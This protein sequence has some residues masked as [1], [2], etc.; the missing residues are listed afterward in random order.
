[1]INF[2]AT[3][4]LM[5]KISKMLNISVELGDARRDSERLYMQ[6]E[7]AIAQKPDLQ[8]HLK[9]L[10]EEYRKGKPQPHK[11]INQNIVKEIEDL[12]KGNLGQESGG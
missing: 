5:L 7:Q 9:I 3:Y 12:L 4:N 8:E 11:S 2:I 6:I 1:V 10:E